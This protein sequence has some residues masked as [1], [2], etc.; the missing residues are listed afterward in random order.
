MPRRWNIAILL[1]VALGLGVL[2]RDSVWAILILAAESGPYLLIGFALA[3]FLKIIIPEQRVFK[4]L[5]PNT[6]TSVALASLL[7]IPIPL[8]SCSVLPVATTLRQSG[9]SRG[10]TTSFLISTPE[11]GLD[12]IGITYALLDP[13]MTIARPLAAL[14]TAVV[15]GTLVT[16]LEQ[17]G[18]AGE[19]G[20]SS[21][22][23]DDGCDDHDHDHH[24]GDIPSYATG[25]ERI[26][27][28]T[29][30]SLAYAFG[31][32]M[33]DLTPWLILGFLISGLVVIAVPDNFFTLYVPRGWAAYLLMLVIGTPIY[34]CAAAVTPV[35]VAL[36]AKGLD[37]GAALVLLLVGPA[38]NATTMLVIARLLGKRI[39]AVHLIGVTG[40][41]LLL[42]AILD[43]L[44]PALGIDLSTAAAEVVH[45]GLSPIAAA[46]AAILIFFLV[47]SAIRIRLM[48]QVTQDI[49]RLGARFGVDP[50][51]P[52][53][54][55][56]AVAV[57]G[58][59]YVSTAFSIIGPGEA[60]WVMR[61]GRVV[62][63]V[64]EPGLIIHLPLPF[65]RVERLQTRAVRR[66]ELGFFRETDEDEN[67]LPWATAQS[68]DA[69]DTPWV[70]M[71]RDFD[72]EAEMMT[73]EENIL[74]IQYAVHFDIRDPYAYRYR[75]ADPDGLVRSF[76]SWV[77][78]QAVAQ[79]AASDILVVHRAALERECHTILQR[80]LDAMDSG[81]RVIAVTLQDVHAALPVHEAFR[82]VA[83][84]L[85]DKAR[86]TRQA[87]GYRSE[88]LAL[89]RAEAYAL[90]QTAA[91][92]QSE[93]V[94]RARGQGQAFVSRLDAYRAHPVLTR[95]RLYFETLETTLSDAQTTFL[96]GDD[97]VVELWKSRNG[98]GLP[99][100]MLQ[101]VLPEPGGRRDSNP[102][103]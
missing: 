99:G 93:V 11:T 6:F 20:S 61:F 90:T 74:S 18:W 55:L 98:K 68:R 80:E 13:I 31:P 94:N 83:S 43:E 47:R 79:R 37:P 29:R 32:L 78:R 9:A 69:D 67:A 34:I 57:L 5:G 12:S 97:V 72:A 44:Y 71:R 21:L 10:A 2:F 91:G 102:T 70:S 35:A 54:R 66:V 77:L 85:E 95:L 81:I 88:T 14:T 28:I 7:G 59:A 4:Y 87:Q 22:E 56:T 62:R 63:T 45:R 16:T 41:A 42:G 27:E 51:S 24:A 46:A 1:I 89:A 58:L 49:R 53:M 26:R 86:R 75:L 52:G 60:G 84:A 39:L 101:S 50:L 3:G 33:D 64:S 48:P 36:I 25:W 82:D 100:D 30:R 73:G 103:K 19:P 8:C 23:A 15:T 96:L 76:A 65:D 92:Y 40:C 17:L 38:T